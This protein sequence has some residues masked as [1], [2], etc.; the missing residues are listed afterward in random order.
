MLGYDYAAPFVW[1]AAAAVVAGVT[2]VVT[3]ATRSGVGDIV[4]RKLHPILER[5]GKQD[6]MMQS[7]DQGLNDLS[8]QKDMENL[9]LWNA[10]DE[11]RHR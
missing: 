9:R 10:I 4:E 8:R 3:T 5:L 1:A 7:I 11:L 6:E 2:W